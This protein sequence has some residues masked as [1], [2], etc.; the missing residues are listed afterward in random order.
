MLFPAYPTIPTGTPSH[1]R[2]LA[3]VI[4]SPSAL[5]PLSFDLGSTAEESHA[6][7]AEELCSLTRLRSVPLRS[8]S[9]TKPSPLRKLYT[10]EADE[11]T[12][13]ELFTNE[14]VTAEELHTDEAEGFTTEEL[15]TDESRY[16]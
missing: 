13:E 15:L 12:A 11:L 16:R 10:D 1:L 4:S 5:E 9:L 14:T 8:C 3:M 7:Q 2:Q 6:D